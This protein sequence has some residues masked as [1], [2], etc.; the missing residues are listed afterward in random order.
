VA[1]ILTR[2]ASIVTREASYT[3][4]KRTRELVPTFEHF[5]CMAQA[6]LSMSAI[7]IGDMQPMRLLDVGSEA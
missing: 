5:V 4:K 2:R 3:N 1:K 7:V 6:R